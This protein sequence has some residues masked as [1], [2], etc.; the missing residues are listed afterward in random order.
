M[1]YAAS[2]DA[3]IVVDPATLLPYVREE[4]IY[5]YASLGRSAADKILQSEHLLFTT[6]YD[7]PSPHAA[8]QAH[9]RP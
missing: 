9:R 7:A 6:R 4:R 1:A 8:A 5:W 2:T 3:R